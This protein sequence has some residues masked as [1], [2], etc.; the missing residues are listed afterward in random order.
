[1]I[2]IGGNAP[3]NCRIFFAIRFFVNFSKNLPQVGQRDANKHTKRC[4]FSINCN[5]VNDYEDQV[6]QKGARSDDANICE[7]ILSFL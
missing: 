3:R 1:M 4:L 5:K 7:F 2:S 6:I